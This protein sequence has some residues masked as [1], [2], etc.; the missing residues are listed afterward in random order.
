MVHVAGAVEVQ[1]RLKKKLQMLL[2]QL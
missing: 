2:L 1:Q